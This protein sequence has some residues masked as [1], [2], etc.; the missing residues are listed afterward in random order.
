VG[1]VT[2]DAAGVI[3]F[4]GSAW[5]ATALPTTFGAY[6][7]TS[8]LQSDGYL[9]RLD[10]SRPPA[11]QLLYSTFLGGSGT[12]EAIALG[13]VSG[14]LA[15]V[16]VWTSSTDLQ[17]PP[18]AY[19]RIYNGG[20]RDGYVAQIDMRASMTV[21]GQGCLG[22]GALPLELT[23]N[24]SPS[25]PNPSFELAMRW[26]FGPRLSF[27]ALGSNTLTNPIPLGR[28]CMLFV[29]PIFVLL[30]T[31]N[32]TLHVPIPQDASLLDVELVWQG[33]AVETAT[34]LPSSSNALVTRLGRYQ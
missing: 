2:A 16:V 22:G 17:T 34:L 28:G 19:D 4:V 27:F 6:D 10:P 29:D 3:T 21:V 14:T 32:R 7:R 8:D 24:G 13:G 1:G 25:I 12:E 33:V 11:Q 15:T 23:T 18:N 30:G 26:L 5:Q 9:A 31:T 20:A